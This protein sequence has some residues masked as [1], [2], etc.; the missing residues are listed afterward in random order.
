MSR[1]RSPAST[2]SKSPRPASTARLSAAAISR[3]GPATRPSVELR[4]PRD[5]RKPVPRPPQGI[6]GDDV[7]LRLAPPAR[8]GEPTE[9]RLPFTDI[10]EAKLV[11]TDALIDAARSRLTAAEYR[12]WQRLARPRC[13]RIGNWRRRWPKRPLA[14][15][16]SNSCRSPTRWPATRSIDRPVVL[17]A[18]E[19][20]MQRAAGALRQRERDPGRDRSQD[21]RDPCLALSHVVETVENDKTE[22]SPG[23]CPPQQS[24]RQGRRHHRRDR[25]RRSI[26]AASPP[27][28]PSR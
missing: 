16:G 20:A 14:P 11:M 4:E 9:A 8:G 23:R 21:R 3:A 26:S 27:R 28:T 18:M 13:K 6:D 12:R 17:Q 24:R 5:G 2:T 10:A 7:R 19:E 25:C 22:I 1:I 15:T